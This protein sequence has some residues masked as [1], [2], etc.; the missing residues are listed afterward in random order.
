[1]LVTRVTS[2]SFTPANSTRIYAS[3]SVGAVGSTFAVADATLS[4]AA[5]DGQEFS[6]TYDG[7]TYLLI[8]SDNPVPDDVPAGNVFYFSTGST[9]GGTVT[10]LAAEINGASKLSAFLS[11]NPNGTTLELSGSAAGTEYNGI[12]FKTGSA[13][14]ATPNFTL[15]TL[16]G[17]AGAGSTDAV[18]NTFTLKTIGKGNLYNNSTSATDTGEQFSDGSLK[19]GSLDNLRWEVS[20]VNNTKG[21]FNLEIRRGD[22]NTNNPI[23][24]ET[25]LNCS[26]DPKSDNYIAR[27]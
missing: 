12:V 13:A 23:V 10:N 19:S 20:G 8:A 16:A 25:F 26:L 27:S 18:Y 9:P 3:S 21:T 4:A 6:I 11:A 17:G 1:M 22:D 24:L 5:V 14:G 15:A 7:T 2:G